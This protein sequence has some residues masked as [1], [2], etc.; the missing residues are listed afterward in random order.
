MISGRTIFIIALVLICAIGASA[1][2]FFYKQMPKTAFVNTNE[3][4]SDFQL[5]KELE[6]KYSAAEN[7]RKAILDSLHNDLQLLSNQTRNSKSIDRKLEER[8]NSSQE[9]F[10]A[11]QTRFED[12]NELL[13]DKYT[14]EIW[15]RINIYVKEYGER[16]GYTY[17]YGANG[18]GNLMY[19][20]NAEDITAEV[21]EYIN[22]RYNGDLK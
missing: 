19:A 3:L 21:K 2:I 8:Y 4:Y 6:K 11:V 22:K 16:N 17:I 1:M 9:T 20:S 10:Y 12:E 5:K 7:A 14:E 13:R 18:E 15:N